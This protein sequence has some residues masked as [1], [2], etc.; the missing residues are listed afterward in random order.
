MKGSIFFVV[1]MLSTSALACKPGGLPE[2]KILDLKIDMEKFGALK[3]MAT[4]YQQYL[5]K[6]LIFPKKGASSCFNN[7]FGVYYL[8]QLEKNLTNHQSTCAVQISQVRSAL[9]HLVDEKSFENQ[10]VPEGQHREHLKKTGLIL[11]QQ[12]D[13]TL[14][15]R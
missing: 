5:T 6:N 10:A 7:N 3:K 9:K 8:S 1:L 2:C 13:Q 15:M 4:E 12:I 14:P 11:S